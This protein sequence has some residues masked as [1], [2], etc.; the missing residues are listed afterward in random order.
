MVQGFP[1]GPVN[2]KI[3]NNVV[4]SEI[5]QVD[6]QSKEPVSAVKDEVKDQDSP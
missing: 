2:S 6:S 3:S 4:T 1:G 5:K